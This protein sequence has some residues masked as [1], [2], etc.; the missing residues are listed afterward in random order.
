[1]TLYTDEPLSIESTDTN[2]MN[3]FLALIASTFDAHSVVLF[4]PSSE[5]SHANL[6]AHFSMS[7]SID[8]GAVIAQGK[9]LVGWILRNK[10]PLLYNV[11]EYNQP[12]LGY[13]VDETEDYI[14]S[15]VGAPVPGGGALCMDSKKNH[16]FHENKQHLLH[17]FA[18]LVPQIQEIIKQSKRSDNVES[19]FRVLEQ[20]TDLKK[21]YTGWSSYLR[22]LLRL[23]SVG[24]G[25]E[26]VAF[27]SLSNKKDYYLVEGEYPS[28]LSEK[29]FS[30]SGGI[31]GW[32]FRNEVVVQSDGKGSPPTPPIFGKVDSF[33]TFYASVC[34]PIIVEKNTVAVLIFA[35][36]IQKDLNSELKLLTRLVSEDLAQFLEVVSLRY[37]V[38][39]SRNTKGNNIIE[40]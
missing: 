12:N 23:L 34:L 31:V 19:Y 15:F 7:D 26:Y 33:P 17:L 29:E 4:Q 32:V 35:S 3:E 11:A 9:G 39:K 38:Y 18:K 14:R 24:C 1:M 8:T 25:F 28:L 22:K 36:T 21:N 40:S 16:F 20:L 30:F 10:E 37:R 27:A 2:I 6:L 13:Y 5:N